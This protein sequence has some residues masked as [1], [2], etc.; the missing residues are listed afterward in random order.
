MI[1]RF[2]PYLIPLLGGAA[3]F[4][5]G[6]YVGSQI[7]EKSQLEKEAAITEAINKATEQTAKAISDIKVENKTIVRNF[8]TIEKNAT[9]YRDCVHPDDSIRVFNQAL[10]NSK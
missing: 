8:R 4:M 10:T 3:L 7:T 1:M 2:M 6:A 9:V 5:G